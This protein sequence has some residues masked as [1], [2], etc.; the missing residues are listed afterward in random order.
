VQI[1]VH[2]A[3]K[4]GAAEQSANAKRGDAVKKALVDGGAAAAKIRIEQA[5]ARAPLV[6]PQDAKHRER[7]A[8]VEIVFIAPAS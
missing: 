6:D 8:R 1:V 3:D 7:N 2:D 5:G 4:P